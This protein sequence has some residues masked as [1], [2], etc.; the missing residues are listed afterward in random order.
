MYVDVSWAVPRWVPC[1]FFSKMLNNG[2]ACFESVVPYT[3]APIS[4][5]ADALN[6]SSN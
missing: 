3:G 5:S 1:N 2:L 4:S 6:L